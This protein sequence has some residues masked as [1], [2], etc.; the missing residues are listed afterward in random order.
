MKRKM[1]I[2]KMKFVK[3]K[4]SQDNGANSTNPTPAPA[5]SDASFQHKI[6]VERVAP[7]ESKPAPLLTP[8][9]DTPAMMLPSELSLAKEISF[10]KGLPNLKPEKSAESDKVTP[11]LTQ[12]LPPPPQVQ[13]FTTGSNR[14]TSDGRA[15]S[16][17]Q[18]LG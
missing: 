14:S 1:K 7:P 16:K 3:P 12:A 4:V 17:C 18:G 6:K 9:S 11:T 15:L 2:A 10:E 5:P 13:M 8:P